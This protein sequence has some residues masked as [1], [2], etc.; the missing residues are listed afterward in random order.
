MEMDCVP[1]CSLIVLIVEL[2]APAVVIA[3]TLTPLLC[4]MNMLQ[5][6]G[7]GVS[8]LSASVMEVTVGT[9]L[10]GTDTASFTVNDE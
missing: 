1:T 8:V 3:D 9:T 10:A 2:Y 6:D 4:W 5:D 7:T